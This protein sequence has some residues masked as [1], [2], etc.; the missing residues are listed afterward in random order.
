MKHLQV[1]DE[2][3]LAE[4]GHPHTLLQDHSGMFH[5]MLRCMDKDLFSYLSNIALQS[6]SMKPPIAVTDESEDVDSE[7]GGISNLAFSTKF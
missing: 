4:F 6:Y 5:K 2:G 3:K 7:E 1:L